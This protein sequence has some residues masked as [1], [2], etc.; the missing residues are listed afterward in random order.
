MAT[1]K[2][3]VPYIMVYKD[4]MSDSRFESRDQFVHLIIKSLANQRFGNTSI[5][6]IDSIAKIL[7]VVANSRSK[8]MVNESMTRMMD[9]GIIEVYENMI[10]SERVESI[11]NS[12]SYFVKVNDESYRSSYFTKVYYEDIYKIMLIEEKNKHKLFS[13]YY[14][15]I[16]RIY[17]S[18]SS[19]KYTLPNIEDIED[20]TGVNRKTVSKYLEIL[21]DKKLIYYE[22]MRMARDKTKNVYGRWD[23]RGAVRDFSSRGYKDRIDLY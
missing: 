8:Q 12:E 10:C 19:D 1:D 15:I 22:T 14:N 2:D 7:G 18:V 20:E 23:D 11:K 9:S 5:V 4:F 17:S 3:K 6:S 16:S 21:M 13:V